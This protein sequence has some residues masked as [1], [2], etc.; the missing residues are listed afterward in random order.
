M[1]DLVLQRCHRH[2]QREAVAR[3]LECDRFFCRECV[4]EHRD[5]VLCST[6]LE[7]QTGSKQTGNAKTALFFR[8]TQFFCGALVIWLVFFLMGH[9][10]ISTPS[11]FHEGTVWKQ[12]RRGGP[13]ER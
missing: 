7:K 2:H 10:L 11:T 12:P 5:R 6:C 13:D 9:L 8:M 3:C 1:Q 4:T